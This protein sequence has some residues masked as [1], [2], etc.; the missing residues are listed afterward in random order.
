MVGFYRK[1]VVIL[2]LMLVNSPSAFSRPD[3]TPLGP[4]IADQGSSFYHFK[5]YKVESADTQRHYKIW[6]AIPN[7]PAPA[8]GYPI[9]YLL[10]GN[11]SLSR[12]N[13]SQL[14]GISEKNP[15]VLV[16]VGYDTPL[17]FDLKARSFDYTPAARG[18]T[19]G[20]S[21]SGRGRV[22]GGSANFRALLEQKILPQSEASLPIDQAK[23][24]LWGHSFGGLFVL[25]AYLHSSRFSHYFAASPSLGQGYQF[26]V[27]DIQAQTVNPATLT[28]MVGSSQPA[29]AGAQPAIDLSPRV[30]QWQKQG[31]GISIVHYPELSHGAMFG[32]SLQDT[33]K[34]VSQ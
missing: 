15:A 11:S 16:F 9:L 7:K 28:L 2:L 13:E 30:V 21:M 33:L 25:D 29:R 18:A 10:D 20:N 17:P 23:R 19:E 5:T 27:D 3:M 24:S 1:A 34:K 14:Q 22:G 31:L 32:V 26:L 8:Q 6:V 12:L 4:S